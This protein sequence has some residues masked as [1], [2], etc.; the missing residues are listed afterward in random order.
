MNDEIDY[1]CYDRGFDDS[2]MVKFIGG[3]ILFFLITIVILAILNWEY[4]VN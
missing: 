2:A 3:I 4:L 1:D